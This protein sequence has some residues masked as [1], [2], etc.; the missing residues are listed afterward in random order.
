M[1]EEF[2][3]NGPKR[4]VYFAKDRRE[5]PQ[6]KQITLF[7]ELELS[8]AKETADERSDPAKNAAHEAKNAAEE[9]GEVDVDTEE[10]VQVQIE[11]L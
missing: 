3:H 9:T 4:N 2:D 7:Q 8:A 1:A 6:A 11:S 10:E 5:K